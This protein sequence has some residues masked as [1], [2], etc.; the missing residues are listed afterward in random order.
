MR[1]PLGAKRDGMVLAVH[2]GSVTRFMLSTEN[3]KTLHSGTSWRFGVILKALAPPIARGGTCCQT[4]C[5]VQISSERAVSLYPSLT[6]SIRIYI[7]I[8]I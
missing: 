4:P 1:I 6:I 7:Y 3:Q 2:L 5:K 8:S